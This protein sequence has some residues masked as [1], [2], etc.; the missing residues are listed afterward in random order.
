[1]SNNLN[2]VI[3]GAVLLTLAGNAATA[4][5]SAAD[6]YG[7]RT[8]T[9]IQA[10]GAGGGFATYS[11]LVEKHLPRFIPGHPNVQLQFMPGAGGVKAA[12]YVYNVAA[13]DGSVIGM[14]LNTV[15]LYQV[16]RPKSVKYDAAKF[17]WLV[18]L[19]QLNSVIVLWHTAPA[20]TLADARKMALVIGS[21]AKSADNYQQPMLANF[22]LGTKFK[23]VTGYDGS[24]GMNLAMERGE[25]SGRMAFWESLVTTKADWLRDRKVIP[26]V[27]VGARPIGELPGVPRMIDLVKAADDKAMVRLLHISA[28]LGRTLYAPPGVPTARAAALRKAAEAMVKDKAFLDEARKRKITIDPTPASELRALIVD[29]LHT[30]AAL[31]ERYKQAVEFN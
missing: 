24:A 31:V 18:G 26:L 21:T 12:N 9:Y 1:M 5:D 25:T 7:G 29:A 15:A 8:I 6:F 19:V 16:L 20:K 28:V 22:L 14:P 2:G 3:V 27:Q 13:K 17:T 10:S 11:R 4:A 23:L 30:P